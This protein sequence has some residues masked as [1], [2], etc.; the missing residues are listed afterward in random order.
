MSAKGSGI[1]GR[2][3]RNIGLA[4]ILTLPAAMLISVLLFAF[5]KLVL[6]S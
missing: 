4:W 3:I 2:T 5:G 1:Q 6:G